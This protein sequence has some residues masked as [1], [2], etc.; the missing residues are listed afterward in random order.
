MFKALAKSAFVGQIISLLIGG[1]IRLVH[2]TTRV[3]IDGL[4]HY[5]A[6][7]AHGKGVILA[8]WHGRLMMVPAVRQLTERRIYMLISAN[9]DGEIIAN[10][11]RSFDI[12]FIRGSAANP[13]KPGKDKRGASAIAQMVAALK[14]GD[15]VGI[16]P[17][18]PRGPGEKVN[19]GVIK[20]AQLSG[21]PVLPI[22][23]SHSRGWF[24]NTWDRFFLAAPFS[25]GY[26]VANPAIH[27]PQ[28]NDAETVESA[29]SALENALNAVTERVD[30]LAGRLK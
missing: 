9:R 21:A 8:F 19:L 12:D 17:D 7:A 24:M 28:E 25:R 29:R 16:T 15:L 14:D 13:K 10:A 22:S 3:H 11:V 27:I 30:M 20:L 18:G 4:E 5:E 6:A 23:C 26:F 1:Y 2:A